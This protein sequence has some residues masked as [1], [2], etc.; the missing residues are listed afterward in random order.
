MRKE[1]KK[2]EN[3]LA[4][5]TGSEELKKQEDEDGDPLEEN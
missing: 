1:T 2:V 5:E 4:A 3:I